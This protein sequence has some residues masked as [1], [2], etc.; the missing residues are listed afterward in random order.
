MWTWVKYNVFVCRIKKYVFISSSR[1]HLFSQSIN[2]IKVLTKVWREQC[3]MNC[4]GSCGFPFTQT[5]KPQ[6]QWAFLVRPMKPSVKCTEAQ[7]AVKVF[8]LLLVKERW[9]KSL[10]FSKMTVW[11]VQVITYTEQTEKLQGYEIIHWI[12]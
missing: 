9:L 1:L 11:N 5:E 7:K 12:H 4:V 8:L 6:D 2:Y 10:H 3:G